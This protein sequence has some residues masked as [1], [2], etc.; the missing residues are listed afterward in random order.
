MGIKSNFNKFL[1]DTCPQVFNDIHL[2]ELSFQKVAIDISISMTGEQQRFRHRLFILYHID[3]VF[4][5][6]W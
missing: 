2:S 4:T 3:I 1:K 6:N 5:H